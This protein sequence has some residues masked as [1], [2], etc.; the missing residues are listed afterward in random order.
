MC[1]VHHPIC[2]LYSG[3]GVPVSV[4]HSLGLNCFFF[5]DR[6]PPCIVDTYDEVNCLCLKLNV[7]SRNLTN[8]GYEFEFGFGQQPPYRQTAI[9]SFLFI[10]NYCDLSVCCTK[11]IAWLSVK[12]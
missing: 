11:G 8:F 7:I 12:G 9:P 10:D 4:Y 2:L 1:C 6:S 3:S 5:V